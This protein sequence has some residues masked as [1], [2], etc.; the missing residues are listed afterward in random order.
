MTKAEL[1]TENEKLRADNEILKSQVSAF[2]SAIETVLLVIN[3][4]DVKGV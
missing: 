4:I 1:T 2:K 3:N